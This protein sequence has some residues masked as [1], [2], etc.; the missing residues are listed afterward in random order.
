MERLKSRTLW[1]AVTALV[2][3]IL[4]DAFGI[5][6]ESTKPYVDVILGIGAAAGIIVNPSNNKKVKKEEREAYLEKKGL[7]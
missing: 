2:T 4:N 7:K 5:T 6:P 3:M 1:V